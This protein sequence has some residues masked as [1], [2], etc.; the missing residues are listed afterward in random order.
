MS[1]QEIRT[2]KYMQINR[3]TYALES[4]Q[5]C[6]MLEPNLNGNLDME[7]MKVVL[8]TLNLQLKELIKGV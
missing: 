2:L 1:E 3:L 7:S 6:V 8:H 5:A 4:I